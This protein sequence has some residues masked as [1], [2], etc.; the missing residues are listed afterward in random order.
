MAYVDLNPVRAGIASDLAASEHTSVQRRIENADVA[1][2]VEAPLLP[3]S[4]SAAPAMP[5]GLRDYLDLVDLTGR[6]A[7][8]DKRGVIDPSAIPILRRLGLDAASWHRQAF[9]I[10]THYWR[11]VGAV[12]ALL[13]KAS[14]LGQCWLKGGGVSR[15]VRR[16][17]TH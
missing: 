7:R 15:G 11:A 14:A 16:Q 5:L 9:G 4:G 3:I 12:D 10:E 1:R 6:I 8:P 13:T 2:H 17:S